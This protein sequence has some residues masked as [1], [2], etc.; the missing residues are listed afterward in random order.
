MLRIDAA[1]RPRLVAII[2][3]LHIRATEARTNGWLGEVQALQ[4]SLDA[5]RAKLANLDRPTPSGS[6]SLG[7]PTLR[8]PD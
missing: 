2:D 8:R 3:N 1:Q 4:I 5:A 6:T 7:I